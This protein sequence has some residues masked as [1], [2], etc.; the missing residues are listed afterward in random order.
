MGEYCRQALDCTRQTVQLAAT[1]GRDLR[2]QARSIIAGRGAHSAN[3]LGHDQV[4][5]G[6]LSTGGVRTGD[7][8][9]PLT[10]KNRLRRTSGMRGRRRCFSHG[11]I[12]RYQIPA[13][14]PCHESRTATCHQNAVMCRAR[15]KRTGCAAGQEGHQMTAREAGTI[16]LAPGHT[17]RRDVVRRRRLM[18]NDLSI[19]AVLGKIEAWANISAFTKPPGADHFVDTADSDAYRAATAR[20]DWPAVDRLVL[21]LRKNAPPTTS[22]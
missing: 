18:L 1:V 22:F 11:F 13:W 20:R 21:D 14:R 16:T 9:V 10:H 6:L 17:I 2:A 3:V 8:P 12:N 19:D 7:D 5:V 4:Q 15:R